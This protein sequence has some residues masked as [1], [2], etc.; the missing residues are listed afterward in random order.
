MKITRTRRP[1]LPFDAGIT[2]RRARP[3]D[4]RALW[5]L[6]ALDSAPP[7]DC[8]AV[9]AEHDGVLIAALGSDGRAIA[10][11]FRHTASIVT[12]LRSLTGAKAVAA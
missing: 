6:A 4:Q 1:E 7:L 12:M 3:G 10:D 8:D 2:L 9:V 11:P 5:R